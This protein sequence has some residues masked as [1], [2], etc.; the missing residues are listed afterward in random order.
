M[1]I[2]QVVCTVLAVVAVTVFAIYAYLEREGTDEGVSIGIMLCAILTA[3]G[4]IA[5]L[6]GAIG[7]ITLRV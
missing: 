7:L 5:L 4:F 3:M 2:F 1:S 6:L